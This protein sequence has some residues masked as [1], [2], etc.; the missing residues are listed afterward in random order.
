MQ[1]KRSAVK[2][3]PLGGKK[4]TVTQLAKD[5]LFL[6]SKRPKLLDVENG[7]YFRIEEDINEQVNKTNQ[8]N[9][10]QDALRLSAMKCEVCALG[11]FFVAKVLRKDACAYSDDIYRNVISNHLKS[12]ISPEQMGLIE[13]AFEKD[14]YF[15]SAPYDVAQEAV[16]FGRKY[17]DSKSRLKAICQNI[18]DNRGVF[19]PSKTKAME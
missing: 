18:I 15:S 12:I 1:A 17:Y 7:S 19:R 6:L 11:A 13:A 8:I 16:D 9:D 3:P 10:L 14:S 2:L 5:V 4:V